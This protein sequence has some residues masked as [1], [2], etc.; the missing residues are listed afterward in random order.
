[1]DSVTFTFDKYGEKALELVQE[2]KNLFI[3]GKAGTGKTT[4]LRH[5]IDN[6]KKYKRIVVAAPTGVAANNAG[7]VTMHSL[8]GL[9]LVPYLPG[10]KMR[11][12][13]SL[14]EGQAELLR[15]IDMLIIDEVSMVR[16]DMLDA[17]DRILCYYR[18]SRKPFGGVQLIMFGDLF[19]LMPVA[20]DEE[21]ITLIEEY[22]TL[23]FFGSKA[24]SKLKYSMLEL[25]H[26]YRQDEKVFINILNHIRIGKSSTKDLR[27]L[28]SRYVED[29][30]PKVNQEVTV[31]MTHNRQVDRYN[32]EQLSKLRGRSKEFK[33]RIEGF[34]PHDDYPVDY[35]LEFKKGARVMFVKND[36]EGR[37]YNGT[38]GRVLS[39]G[40]DYVEVKIDGKIQP[41]IV[42]K[43]RWDKIIYKVNKKTKEII[44]EICGSYIQIPLRLAWA[45]T[46]HKSQG[47]TFDNVIIDA[48]KAFASGQVYVALSRCRTL[49]GIILK[50][51][52]S[53]RIIKSDPD[54]AK[55]MNSVDTILLDG[56]QRTYI[57]M[58][59]EEWEPEPL[60]V[61]AGWKTI[62]KIRNG[63]KAYQRSID[64]EYIYGED[65]FKTHKG[66]YVIDDAFKGR[67]RKWRVFDM[68]GGTCPFVPRKYKFLRIC[69]SQ[70][71]SGVTVEIASTNIGMNKDKD[72]WVVQWRLG[73]IIKSKK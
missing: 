35:Y 32:S 68:N 66:N 64:D 58:Q 25:Q 2:G 27:L 7:G 19:Q 55:Y 26:V 9:P 31:L 15:Q 12:L 6:N 22:D 3:T 63:Q 46:V 4:L 28:N 60:V 11:D 67:K 38:M 37:Y 43:Q 73:N 57:D 59:E 30:R 41:V 51:K 17:T 5:I 61:Y 16:C 42:E 14:D 52:I 18:K 56:R 44:T 65:I 72:L 21:R 40:D 39:L 1:M 45:V 54:V 48:D 10:H 53:S 23:Y 36:N 29:Y 34:F 13:Y 33:A 20:K 49:E 62:D 70:V 8:F 69:S 47:L 71:G 24:L 50:S